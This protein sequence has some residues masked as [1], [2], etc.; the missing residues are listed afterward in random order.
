MEPFTS[1]QKSLHRK[2][3]EDQDILSG[4]FWGELRV[5]LAVA[6]AGSFNRAADMLGMSHPTV[7]RQVKRLQDLMGSQLVVPTKHGL[8]FTEKGELLAQSVCKLDQQLFALSSGIKSK[9]GEIE[10]VV[11]ISITDALSSIFLAPSLEAF[12]REHP[13]IQVH[14]KTPFNITDLK[15]NQT[16]MMVGFKSVDSGDL[17]LQPLGILHFIPIAS[18]TYI[19]DFGLPTHENISSHRFIQSDFYSARTGLWDSWLDLCERGTIA[20]FCDHPFAYG[21]LVKSGMGI[22]LLASYTVL[23][24]SSVPLNLDAR[25][26]VP[27]YLIAVRQRL[28]S[29][30][31]RLVFDWL[32]SVLGPTNPWFGE[33]LELNARP[34][35]YDRGFRLLFNIDE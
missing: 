33:K 1:D 4:Q 3:M 27:M 32:S 16:D 31:V 18:K 22:G 12:S 34:S 2:A 11:R 21:M 15:E 23:E 20:H 9:A 29:R 8:I 24:P 19:R 10:G 25:I 30:P 14:L 26:S 7:S 5:F 28:E 35:A 17:A 6:K 13:K